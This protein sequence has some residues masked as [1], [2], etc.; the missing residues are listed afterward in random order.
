[1]SLH[2]TRPSRLFRLALVLFVTLGLQAGAAHAEKAWVP[3]VPLKADY[4]IVEKSAHRLTLYY[5]HHPVKTYHIALGQ[6]GLAPKR[7]TGDQRTPEGVYHIVSHNADSHY[8]YALRISYPDAVDEVMARADGM[9][10]GGDIMI[11]GSHNG[12]SLFSWMKRQR[13]DG[14]WTNGCIAVKDAEIDEIA[15][16][17]PDGTLIEIRP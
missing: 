17:V 4:I 2:I 5:Q 14:D 1:M 7:H 10:P 11:H 12:G 16:A 8:H 13:N 6:G 15:A 9:T 3:P